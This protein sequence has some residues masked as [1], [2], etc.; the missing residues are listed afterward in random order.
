MCTFF[1]DFVKCGTSK[2]IVIKTKFVISN[3]GRSNVD[4][5]FKYGDINLEIVDNFNYLGVHFCKNGS[6]NLNVKELCENGY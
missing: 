3:K 5:S 6:I 1:E 2:S 4:F